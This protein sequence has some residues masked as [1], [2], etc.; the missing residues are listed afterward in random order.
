MKVGI[1]QCRAFP[2]L[3]KGKG[4]VLESLEKIC[5]DG[6]FQAV[7][8]TTIKKPKLRAQAIEMV[9]SARL[10]VMFAAQPILL[11]NKLNLNAPDVEGRRAAVNAVNAAVDEATEWGAV[12]VAVLAGP[13]VGEENREEAMKLLISSLKECC[14]YSR[15]N[16]GPAILLESSDRAPFGRNSLIGPTEEGAA[17]AKAVA[18][19]YPRFGLTIDLAQLPL[20]NES[21]NH[22]VQ[23]A[24]EHLK[25]VHVGNCVVSDSKHPAY[26]HGQPMFGIPEGE[27]GIPEVKALLQALLEAG[28]IREG[29]QEIV[30]FDVGPYG[31]QTSDEV[32]QNAKETLD[33]AWGEL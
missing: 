18:S 7:E 4:P 21:P 14:E 31:N 33:A 2:Q 8:V 27:N 15:S 9:R 32:L 24:G 6:Y 1:V 11:G 17:V 19:Y 29:G 5:S 23:A 16:D 22:A 13:D 25:H 10:T 26:G 12:A 20:L 28:Y 30:S 3:S